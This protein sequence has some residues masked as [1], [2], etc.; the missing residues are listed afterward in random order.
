MGWLVIPEPGSKYGPCLEPCRHLD[1]KANREAA[2]EKCVT[3]AD[4][5]GFDVPY[6]KGEAGGL[7]HAK[8]AWVR[9]GR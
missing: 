9:C 6:Y 3:C 1:C 5:I 4:P 2:A 8:C 7:E